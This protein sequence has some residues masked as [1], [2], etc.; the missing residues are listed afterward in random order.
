MS[1]RNRR[2]VTGA[3]IATIISLI[4]AGG[5]NYYFSQTTSTSNITIVTDQKSYVVGGAI[6]WTAS[7]LTTGASYIVGAD[8]NGN[9]YHSGS[10][11]AI[12][13]AMKGSYSV[14]SNVIGA[15]SFII[16][17]FTQ[18]GGIVILASTPITIS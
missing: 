7:G 16:G 13:S 5:S 9:V 15:T 4:F 18:S 1:E 14:G 12:A 3:V 10:F 11:T 8:L 6:N 17:Q 2:L